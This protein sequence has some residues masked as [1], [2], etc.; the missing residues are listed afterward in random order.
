VSEQAEL[1]QSARNT[2][3]LEMPTTLYDSF[4]RVMG[5][6]DAVG[7]VAAV[8]LNDLR[9]SRRKNR[10]RGLRRSALPPRRRQEGQSRQT[11][12]TQT[13]RQ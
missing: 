3:V 10:P 4:Q 7:T 5:N 2:L 11:S 8:V 6:G 13:S 1:V 9:G 12:G